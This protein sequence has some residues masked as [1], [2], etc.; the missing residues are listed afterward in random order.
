VQPTGATA[1]AGFGGGDDAD[2]G[3]VTVS[4]GALVAT[5][6]A[7]AAGIGGGNG[8]DGG[9]L[10]TSTTTF[11]AAVS[12]T[13]G[14][15][16][17]SAVGTGSGGT[18]FGTLNNGGGLTIPSG[19]TLRIPSGAS[20]TNTGSI[21]D[22]GTMTGATA[23]GTLVNSGVIFL[24]GGG[25]I[26]GDGDGVLASQV[27]VSV[28]NYKLLFDTNGGPDPNPSPV[29]VYAS[30]ALASG[31]TFPNVAPPSGGVFLGWYTAASG[32]TLV[33]TS[34]D[35]SALLT[36]GPTTTTL[37][38]HYRVPQTITFPIIGNQTF[39][40][41]DFAISATASSGLPVTFSAGP[42]AVCTV[43]GS[44]VHIVGAGSCT[45]NANQAGN[46][47]F[48]PAPQA[49]RTFQVL[50]G[51]ITV[52]ATGSQTYGG[53]PSF[54]P[55]VSLPAGVS[56]SGALSCTHL[57]G[58]VLIKPSLA[59]GSYTI[60]PL[61]CGGIVVTGPNAS[62]YL[63]VLGGGSFV[64]SS[65]EVVVTAK[66][67]QPYL[68]SAT[69]TRVVNPPPNIT[70]TG[71]LT[72]TQVQP[73]TPIDS[74]L[75]VGSYTIN[76]ATCSGLSLSGLQASG[77]HIVYSGGSYTV[78]P[79]AVT[80]TATGTEGYGGSPTFTPQTTLP[81][82]VSLSGTLTCTKLTGN[83]PISSTLSPS[84]YTIDHTSCSG[85][86][87]SGTGAGNYQIAYANGPFTVTKGHIAISTHT[88]TTANALQVHKYVF[89][90]TV[91]NTDA[92]APVA[93]IKVTITAKFG[94]FTVSCSALTDANGVA[95]C[96]S[97][98]GNLFLHPGAAYTATTAAT[99]KYFAGTGT[100]NLGA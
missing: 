25:T 80:V 38:A 98:N 4:G 24:S 9:S 93:N 59:P 21:L 45:V 41:P 89:T 46:A 51:V 35:L 83:I 10:T 62:N 40:A 31:A 82:G 68:G 58:N 48:L 44:T 56:L 52:T 91:T 26:Q 77:Y 50:Q 36:D 100:G 97:G 96:S 64:V 79:K 16:T 1:G 78:T 92:N 57:T 81:S 37:F 19:A 54:T 43:S 71:T 66:G 88:N 42:P 85:L 63:V 47:S 70:V 84:N 39:G 15:G 18:S 11:A 34:T 74:Y 14:G 49:Q 33:T 67:S 29:H 5:G 73:S 95:T 76:P 30:T 65:A 60:D 61:T 55:T 3:T 6:G 23:A 72:C 75:P 28:H 12:A 2:G 8:G 90:S 99:A 53:S 22:K 7:D 20:A 17:S 86:S 87:L 27:T 32:G 69:F 13:D 94:L